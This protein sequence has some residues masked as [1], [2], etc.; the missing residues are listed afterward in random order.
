MADALKVLGRA[1]HIQGKT[2]EALEYYVAALCIYPFVENISNQQLWIE[3][4]SVIREEDEIF[5]QKWVRRT[6][7]AAKER[8]G[9]FLYLNNLSSHRETNITQIFS[10]LKSSGDPRS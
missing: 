3:I 7:E 8:R 6:E 1:K 9:H 2:T 4:Q 10:M 5:F